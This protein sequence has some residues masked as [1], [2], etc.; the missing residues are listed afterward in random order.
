MCRVATTFGNLRRGSFLGGECAE[1]APPSPLRQSLVERI[2][3]HEQAARHVDQT[4][5]GLQQVEPARV[6]SDTS[7]H[8]LIKFSRKEK[9]GLID[10]QDVE[11]TVALNI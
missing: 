11:V 3:I 4:G 6:E 10:D 7:K 5:G 8:D 9:S 2:L 1:R